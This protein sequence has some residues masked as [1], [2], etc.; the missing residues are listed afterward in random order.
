[1]NNP[2]FTDG[3]I[4]I[5]LVAYF[6]AAAA[7]GLRV[8]KHLVHWRGSVL[9][10]GLIA[11]A[12][13]AY[14]LH[15]WIDTP[16]GQNLSLLNMLSTVLWLVTLWAWIT[17]LF[18]PMEDF[19]IFVAPLDIISI[20]LI[21]VIPEHYYVNTIADP[22]QLI[23]ILLTLVVV[24]VL[25]IAALQGILLSLQDGRL[26]KRKSAEATTDLPSIE[27]MERMLFQMIWVGFILLTIVLIF[28]FVLVQ[29][30]SWQDYLK[31]AFAIFA[32]LV[33]LVLLIGRYAAGWRGKKAVRWTLFAVILL[34]IAYVGGLMITL[35][36]G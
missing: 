12:S 4:V 1:M 7:Q 9:L 36:V 17:C 11:L 27:V 29:H 35:W 20:I 26:K 15:V 6:F 10:I 33:L 18:K 16:Q 23:H 34:I 19:L 5:S 2:V 24:S 22:K 28:G 3:L 14:L 25:I 32:W 30:Y 13:H 31:T 8:K 21:L